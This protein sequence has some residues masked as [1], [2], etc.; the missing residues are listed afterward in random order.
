M[1]IFLVLILAESY[2]IDQISSGS[3]DSTQDRV[4]DFYGLGWAGFCAIFAF[5]IGFIV[6]LGIDIVVGCRY[7]NREL[8][9]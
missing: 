8:M 9:E 4:E 1:L 2:L 3:N 6:L 7:S 5:N